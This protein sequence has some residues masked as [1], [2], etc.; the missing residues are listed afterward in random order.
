LAI[1]AAL[2]YQALFANGG[3][4]IIHLAF[5]VGS[6]L[7]S[8]AVS[9][10]KLPRGMTWLGCVAAGALAAIFVLQGAAPLIQNDPLTYLAYQVLGQRPE[11]WLIDLVIFWFVALLLLDSRGKA[12]ILGFVAVSTAVGLEVYRHY[13][14]YLGTSL[15]AVTKI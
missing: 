12:R 4:A 15:E 9:D 3:G 6:V 5:G 1:P 14:S 11:G 13:L 2:L 8:F 10:F 7:L